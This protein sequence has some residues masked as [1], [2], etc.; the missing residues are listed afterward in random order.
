MSDEKPDEE[1]GEKKRERFCWL[2]A[3]LS[4]LLVYTEDS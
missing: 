3:R 4:S 2:Y 1:G